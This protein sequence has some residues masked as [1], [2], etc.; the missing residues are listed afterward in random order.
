MEVSEDLCC[1]SGYLLEFVVLRNCASR[2]VN[3]LIWMCTMKEESKLTN[4]RDTPQD[5]MI[6]AAS[7]IELDETCSHRHQ[8]HQIPPDA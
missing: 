4:V 3:S 6:A 2:C 7:A 8:L 5:I 1:G